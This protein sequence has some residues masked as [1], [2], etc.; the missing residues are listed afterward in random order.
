MGRKCSDTIC[1]SNYLRNVCPH[2]TPNDDCRRPPPS[3]EPSAHRP[4]RRAC[5]SAG[6][7]RA[8]VPHADRRVLGARVQKVGDGIGGD[9][10]DGGGVAG[11]RAVD[12][13]QRRQVPR[14]HHAVGV[15]RERTAPRVATDRTAASWPLSAPAP[16]LSDA[17]SCPNFHERILPSLQPAYSVSVCASPI[18]VAQTASEYTQQPTGSSRSLQK[19]M[20]S[21]SSEGAEGWGGERREG[22][23]VRR[24]ASRDALWGHVMPARAS[25]SERS[26][27]QRCRGSR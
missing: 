18:E 9:G 13:G 10:A 4:R 7:G 25:W 17:A 11:E 2:S 15:A 6:V 12:G 1:T 20:Q 26:R 5:R 16:P 27:T 8:L 22:R 21:C 24:Q 3:S 23:R 19:L 14:L